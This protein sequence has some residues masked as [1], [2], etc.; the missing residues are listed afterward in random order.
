MMYL[1]SLRKER[2]APFTVVCTAH[3]HNAQVRFAC[4][5]SSQAKEMTVRDKPGTKADAYHRKSV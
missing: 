2:N 4:A 1:L 5:R 3:H